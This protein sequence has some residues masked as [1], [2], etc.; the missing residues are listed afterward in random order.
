MAQTYVYNSGSYNGAEDGVI[1]IER[2]LF[3][4]GTNNNHRNVEIR[5]KVQKIEEYED[6]SKPE[7]KS[8]WTEYF[9]YKS[10]VSPFDG[11]YENDFSNVAR[12]WR[13]VDQKNMAFI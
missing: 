4:D 10:V 1:E 8:T 3:F 9:I 2:G 7:N 13:G 6:Q 11:S 12:L 5:K